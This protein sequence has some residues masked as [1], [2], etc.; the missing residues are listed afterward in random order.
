MPTL[1]RRS[2]K[3]REWTP[4]P[5]YWAVV[6]EHLSWGFHRRALGL[7]TGNANSG[8]RRWEPTNNENA[9]SLSLRDP[10][11]RAR[12]I[13]RDWVDHMV[14]S[15][16]AN[17]LDDDALE[18]VYLLTMARHGFTEEQARAAIMPVPKHKHSAH[19]LPPY[20][21]VIK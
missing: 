5:T 15:G 6:L 19:D 1:L 16:M 12:T 21:R 4:A 2:D 14:T 18:A 13:A 10:K 8:A 3:E 11:K 7:K 20:I 9:M 17:T